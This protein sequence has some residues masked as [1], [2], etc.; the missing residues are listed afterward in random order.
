MDIHEL[1]VFLTVAAERSFSKAAGKLHRTQSAVSQAIRRLED[2]LGE[3]LIDRATK[4][5]R[6]TEAGRVLRDYAERLMRLADEAETAVRDLRDLRRG[7]IL[8]GANE[9]AVHGLLPLIARFRERYPGIHVDVRRVQARH[10][11]TEVVQGSLDL[12]LITFP[13]TDPGLVSLVIDVDDLVLLVPPGHALARRR[14]VHMDEVGRQPIVAHNDP[15][16][17]RE[18][19]LRLF[20]ERREAINIVVSLPSLDA[21]KRAVEMGL[22][23]AILPRR[24]AFT[25]LARREL[26]AI[27]IPE[28]HMRRQLRLV[29]RQ[30]AGHSHAAREFIAVAHEFAQHH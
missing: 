14:A 20:E 1:Q 28:L 13:P 25:E 17:A 19:V 26:V 24:L 23:V 22:G 9:G 16:P 12:G 5:G 6:L 8:I 11:G 15:S 30:T 2:E 27:R 29:H 21:I 18:R 7:R 4:D 3:R 10:I